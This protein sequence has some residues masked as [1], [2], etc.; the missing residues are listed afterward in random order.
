[1]K[2]NIQMEMLHSWSKISE[3]QCGLLQWVKWLSISFQMTSMCDVWMKS[4]HV[5]A[6]QNNA[7]ARKVIFNYFVNICW[8]AI[9]SAWCE[10]WCNTSA[11]LQLWNNL[12]NSNHSST[13]IR[14]FKTKAKTNRIDSKGPAG[15]VIRLQAFWVNEKESSSKGSNLRKMHSL[16]IGSNL[17]IIVS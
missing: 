8:T 12:C 5:H 10:N 4:I 9:L 6:V 16:K 11:L 14:Y 17:K 2:S 13:I 1:M 15:N 7:K 3:S